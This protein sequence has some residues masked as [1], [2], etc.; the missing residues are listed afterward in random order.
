MG[1]KAS[2]PLLMGS[3]ACATEQTVIN[4]TVKPLVRYSF[5]YSFH[6]V[7]L[8]KADAVYRDALVDIVD[9]LKN[10]W[11]WSDY[12]ETAMS[13]TFGASKPVPIFNVE[14][15][16]FRGKGGF[17][18][19]VKWLGPKADHATLRAHLEFILGDTITQ[20]AFSDYLDLFVGLELLT[21]FNR[22]TVPKGEFGALCP[23]FQPDP[24]DIVFAEA[25]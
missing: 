1:N 20:Y 23:F 15:Y 8:H 9:Q 4:A 21:L 19:R 5:S 24:D 25:Y 13:R 11:F 3:S 2:L 14:A 18:G 7:P 6:A 17:V 16:F 12:I 10:P 22:G